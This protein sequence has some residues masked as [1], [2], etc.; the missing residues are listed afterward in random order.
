[1]KLKN[2]NLLYF[3]NYDFLNIEFNPSLNI[4]IGNNANGKTNIIEAIF[5]MALGKSFR[6]KRDSECIKLQEGATCI[7]CTL[8]KDGIEKDMMLAISSKGKNAKISDVKKNKLIDFVGELNIVL[9][10]PDDLQLIKG[11][12]AIRREF[13]DREFYQFSRVYHKYSLIY[14]HLLKQ[15]NLF[16]K[17]MRKKRQDDMSKI[18]IET[19][20][21]QLV[22]MAIYITIERYKF[23]ERI[24]KLANHNMLK[25][26]GGVEKLEIEYNSSILKSLNLKDINDTKFNEEEIVKL[27]MSKINDDINS[28]ST[29]IGPHHDD[30]SFFINGMDAKNYASQGQQRTIVLALKLSEIQYLKNKTG[31]YPI[32]LLDDVLSELDKNRQSELL[33]TIDK[34]I[35]TFITAPNTKNIKKE[36]LKNGSVFHIQNGKICTTL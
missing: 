26:S 30:L 4:F 12:P 23:I 15:R 13:M 2:L 10:S 31:Y 11:S 20:T 34:N 27:M 18:Y 21:S 29:K 36:V 6:T 17:D 28:G 22:K 25:I 16:L 8:D 19:L 5:F 32:L 35:Q 1:M 14:K 7:S 24:E 3:R 9:F 33:N